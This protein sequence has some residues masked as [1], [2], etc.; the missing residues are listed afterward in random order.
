LYGFLYEFPRS[1]PLGRREV[2]GGFY[3][4]TVFYL[5][6]MISFMPGI[7]FE[8]IV[9]TTVFYFIVG[10]HLLNGFGYLVTLS[11]GIVCSVISVGVGSLF[12]LLFVGSP[13]ASGSSIS[14]MSSIVMTMGGFYLNASSFP[15]YIFW[16]K[17]ISW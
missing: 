12:G 6:K 13:S 5:G 7:L 1:L 16:L 4:P 8:T 3:R 14:V 9:T 15:I 17:Y 11:V 10:L 2:A